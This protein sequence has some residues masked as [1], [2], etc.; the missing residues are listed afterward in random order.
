MIADQENETRK[1]M[2]NNNK[3]LLTISMLLSL[4]GFTESLMWA[5]KKPPVWLEVKVYLDDPSPSRMPYLG[6]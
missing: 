6:Q 5:H 4:V 1:Q 2:K 3:I